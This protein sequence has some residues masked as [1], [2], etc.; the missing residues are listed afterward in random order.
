MNLKETFEKQGGVK[1]LKQYWKGG[2]FFTAVGEFLLLGKSRT[3]LE[4]LRLSTTLKTKQKL[5]KRYK[6]V[7]EQFDHNYTAEI[8]EP[9]NRIWICWLQ[10]IENAPDV[11]K[12]CYQSV[13]KNNPNKEIILLTADNINEYVQFPEY[14]IVKWKRGI[15]TNTHITDLL[16]LEL[17]IQYGGMWLDAT[18]LCT[19]SAPDYYFNS[20]L[21]FY[22]TLKPGRDGH[23]NY[24][25]SWLMEAKT[26][27]KILMATRELCYEYWKENDSMWDYFLLHD[28]M[29][30]V[31]EYY[32]N[33]WKMVIPKDNATPHI[34]LL[35]LF[36]K[37]DEKI[38]RA[39]IE[40]SPFHK[41]SY[42]F[43]KEQMALEG[44]NYRTSFGVTEIPKDQIKL[45]K[46]YINR[47]D[48]LS[49]REVSGQKI[50]KKLTE[51]E[52][53]IAVD[54]TL[55]FDGEEWLEIFEYEKQSEKPYIFAYFL[56]DNNA[57]RDAVEQF[58]K[59]KKLRVITCPHMD[60][61][62][63]RDMTFGDDQ[64]FEVSPVDFLNLVR[65]AEYIVTDSFHGSVFSILNHK[66]FLTVNRYSD[67]LRKAKNTRIDSLFSLL[68]IE[69][70]HYI[71]ES[72]DIEKAIEA[73][74]D[75][76]EI[77]KRLS[78]LRDKTFDFLKKSLS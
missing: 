18:V 27:N 39:I 44:T 25:S 23:C 64:R 51:R 62:V 20:E 36:D 40:Q 8:H 33:E 1:L 2:A 70:R 55:L 35:R 32:P 65:G 12:Q 28:F 74:I 38:Y 69:N 54:P 11:V 52:A 4:L 77:D 29:S 31:L 49:V 15:I 21:F 75:Y 24:I 78:D 3:S 56:G 76:A 73:D 71:N 59:K 43:T 19:G 22:Q 9:S 14:I 17:L 50:I 68:G 72:L 60:E 47:I 42:K 37:Y 46:Q 26:N 48:F 10:G 7:L 58:A 53:V 16:R 6:Q 61:F 34:L 57:H 45:T 41:L 5:E 63:E 67:S 13:V 66:K 30:I